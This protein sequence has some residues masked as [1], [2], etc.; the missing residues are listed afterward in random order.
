ML[1]GR[2]VEQQRVE[3]LLDTARAGRSEVLAVVGEAGVGKS[4]LLDHAQS[5]AEGMLVLRARGVQSETH[6]PFAG[7]LELL[8]PALRCL[9]RLAAP[10]AAALESALALRPARAQDRFAVG[11]ATL[12]LLTAY[13]EE[14]PVLVLVDDAHWLDASSAAALLFAL[15][16]TLADA[17]GVVLTVRAGEP[18]LLDDADL[19]TVTL[20]GLDRAAA[21]ELVRGH[22]HEAVTDEAVD[23]LLRETGG[24]PLALLELSADRLALHPESP[25]DTPPPVVTSVAQAYLRRCRSLP[26]PTR[27]LLLLAAAGESSDLLV[28]ASAARSLRLDVADLEPAESAGLVRVGERVEFRHPLVRSAVYG[29]AAPDRR[30]QAHRALALA[31]PDAEVDR[32]AWHLALATLGP[33]DSACSALEQAGD[34]A[35]GRSAYDVACRAY[36]RAGRLAP[37]QVRRTRLLHAAADA[38]WL[39][40]RAERALELLDA[41]GPAPPALSVAIAHLRGQI[42]TR[43]G[44][45]TAGQ[46]LLIAGA[47]QAAL[48]DVDRAVV[49]LA[50]ALNAA[51]YAGDA[52]A[53]RDIADRIT[54][55]GGTTF[56]ATIYARMARGMALIF[57]GSGEQG[58]V[59]VR[60]AVALAERSEQLVEDPRLLAW[61]VMGH[62]WLREAQ[63]G[64]TV[65][66]RALEVARRQMAVGALPFLLSLVAIEQAAG[67]RW[68]EAEA[69]FH[70]AISLARET[71]QRTDLAVA[72]ARSA[73]LEAR[74]GKEGACRDHAAEGLAL[75]RELGLGPCEIWVHAAL[76]DLALGLGRHEAAV[77]H[78]EEQQ[79]VLASRGIRD[80]DLSPVPELVDAHLRLR[81]P[82]RA[83]AIVDGFGADAQAKG[84]PWALARAARCRGL[85]APDDAMDEPFETA[86]ALHLQTPDL[87]ETART[88]LA[89]GA[90]L[91]RARQRVRARE[92]LRPAVQ[93]FDRL[94][95]APW[96]DLARTE[97]AATGETARRREPATVNDLTPQEL[98][99]ALMLAGGR[100][101]REAA[102]A[103]FLSPKTVEYHLRSVYRKLDVNSR[104]QLADALLRRG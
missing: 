101:T 102:A 39:G 15:R 22:V 67:D 30:R 98:Q 42:A 103:L 95:A 41:T 92:Q 12:G 70:E 91:R 58:A 76:A 28:L 61:V 29:D 33:D 13:A 65:V 38:A 35:R 93:A 66:D 51:F 69:G 72:L 60:E 11:A 46:Q 71:G 43:L 82:E 27:D 1:V 53:M 96:S 54:T 17:I 34:R 78:L 85:L 87:F 48:V 3:R 100:T 74:Q 68:A 52:T 79:A 99:I 63:A 50:E 44:P 9:D 8:R 25:L 6:V 104:E 4:V 97:L 94:G 19:P 55:L 26:E 62:A 45:V 16:R 59:L 83:A 73:W 86:L 5:R 57:S 64:P 40:G 24:N 81:H 37:D 49:M 80:I 20:H 23:R 47:E 7:L 88:R 90:R 14:S 2:E 10:Q 56:Y 75:S 77:G 18:S 36:E 32:R 31:L 21:A 84:Q 89:Y